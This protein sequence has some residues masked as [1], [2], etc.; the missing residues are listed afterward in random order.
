MDV[1]YARS[2]ALRMAPVWLFF[3]ASLAVGCDSRTIEA[4]PDEFVG[5][6]IVVQTHGDVHVVQTVIAGSPAADAGLE[7][8]AR[9]VAINGTATRGRS[10]ASV[11]AQLRGVA[12]TQVELRLKP[13]SGGLMTAVLTRRTLTRGEAHDDYRSP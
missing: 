11:V 3:G 9:L 2:R 5:I 1:V 13:S 6:G 7:P 8:G 10:L 4:Y 12:G